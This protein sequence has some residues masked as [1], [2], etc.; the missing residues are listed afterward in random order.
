MV[1]MV[2]VSEVWRL[3]VSKMTTKA[4]HTE[5][6]LVLWLVEGAISKIPAVSFKITQ[7]WLH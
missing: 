2:D 7:V 6:V 4:S 5:V 3:M 1:N